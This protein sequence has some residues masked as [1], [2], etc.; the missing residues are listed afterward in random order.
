MSYQFGKLWQFEKASVLLGVPKVSEDREMLATAALRSATS[1]G[2][3]QGVDVYAALSW[4]PAWAGG[5][6]DQGKLRDECPQGFSVSSSH[7]I[8]HYLAPHVCVVEG[9]QHIWTQDFITS[10]FQKHLGTR[11]IF[12]LFMQRAVKH[13][14][15][16]WRQKR[17]RL[18]IPIT[19]EWRDVGIQTLCSHVYVWVKTPNAL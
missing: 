9:S 14:R 13:K 6:E 10:L 17:R 3:W 18:Y 4:E 7:L 11:L 1:R 15:D 16:L 19:S 12:S 5:R 2:N 8:R